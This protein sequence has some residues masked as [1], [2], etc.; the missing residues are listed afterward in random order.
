MPI[1]TEIKTLLEKMSIDQEKMLKNDY[2]E[3]VDSG[4]ITKKVIF[5][6]LLIGLVITILIFYYIYHNLILPINT[7]IQVYKKIAH[8][9]GLEYYVDETKKGQITNLTRSFIRMNKQLEEKKQE[10]IIQQAQLS[11]ENKMSSLGKMAANMAHEI[12]TPMQTVL[13]MAQRVQRKLKKEVNIEDIN[14][15]MDIIEHNIFNISEIIDSLRKVSRNSKNDSFIESPL[16]ELVEDV[17]VMSKE[18]FKINNIKFNIIYTELSDD[19]KVSCQKLQISQVLINVINNAYNA[20]KS[21]DEK[22]INIE[23]SRHNAKLKIAITDSGSGIPEHISTKIFTPLFT[24]NEIGEG[25]GLGLSISHDI[26]L[27]HNGEIYLDSTC[28]NTRF[29]ILLPMN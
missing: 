9:N 25:T 10:L 13:L 7:L 18:R 3:M 17:L 27:K 14:S 11:H 16:N 5:T 15:S 23:F 6:G 21:L 2:I 1:A 8:N 19:T 26:L 22:W 24:T 28:K 4:N 29:I 20:I 12:N